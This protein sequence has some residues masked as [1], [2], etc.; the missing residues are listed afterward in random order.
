MILRLAEEMADCASAGDVQGVLLRIGAHA[1]LLQRLIRTGSDPG[2]AG[3]GIIAS[4]QDHIRYAVAKLQ[5]LAPS[6]G[7]KAE[8]L[9]ARR[10]NVARILSCVSS[11]SEPRRSRVELSV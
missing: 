11:R 3:R 10:S 7:E 2:D 5:S 8:A 9:R 1:E 6:L 4:V